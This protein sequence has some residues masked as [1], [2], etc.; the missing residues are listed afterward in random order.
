[1]HT[2]VQVGTVSG[3]GGS[4]AAVWAGTA[5]SLVDLHSFLPVSFASSSA[6][7]VEV[8]AGGVMIIV[9]T[10]YNSATSR[11]EALMWKS[12]PGPN[13]LIDPDCDDAKACT[14]D[15]CDAQLGCTWTPVPLF[16]DIFP[17]IGD[18]LVDID[19][20]VCMLNGFAEP[21][22]CPAADIIPCGQ[23]NGTIDVD[24]LIAL[25]LAFADEPLCP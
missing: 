20:L 21:P 8:D 16:G 7:G 23:G 19:D 6:S 12:V 4:H 24:D 5:E 11:N 25:L 15:H 10:G 22:Q 14:I 18:C 3:A 1:I 13:C 2:G 9:G 17:T